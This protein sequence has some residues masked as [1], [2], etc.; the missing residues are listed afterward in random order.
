MPKTKTKTSEELKVLE[1]KW[2]RELIEAGWTVLPAALIEH[3]RA[4]GLDA[5]DINIILHLANRWWTA[6]NRPMPS[7]NSIAEAM[8]IDPS[9]VRRRIQ[10]MEAAGFVRREERRVSKVGSK[11]NIYHLD[12]LIENLKPFAADMVMK[13]KE[14]M[15]ER[16]ARFAKRGRPKLA[17]VKTDDEI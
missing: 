17:L 16:E 15:A 9:T 6:D 5:L 4:L 11:T 14:R 2:S 12:G 7:K 13:K 1:Q 3:Q 10:R 8:H